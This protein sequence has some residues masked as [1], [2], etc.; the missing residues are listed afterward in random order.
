MGLQNN[1]MRTDQLNVEV[2]YDR[3]VTMYDNIEKEQKI[4]FETMQNRKKQL[5]DQSIRFKKLIN[6]H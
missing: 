5:V 4:L 2:A 6:H 1:S 3:L